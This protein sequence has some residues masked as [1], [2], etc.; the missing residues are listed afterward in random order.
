[1]P[2]LLRFASL[3]GIVALVWAPAAVAIQPD[4]D[5]GEV[6][7]LSG[8]QQAATTGPPT[9]HIVGVTDV[10]AAQRAAAA[11]QLRVLDV[12]PHTRIFR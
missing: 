9:R 5:S 12:A 10:A 4:G 3:L 6:T 2:T 7:V 8:A 11:A 1:M